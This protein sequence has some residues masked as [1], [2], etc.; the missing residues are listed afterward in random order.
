MAIGKRHER[1]V[2]DI[3]GQPFDPLRQLD[4]GGVE[5]M[6]WFEMEYCNSDAKTGLSRVEVEYRYRNRTRTKMVSLGY[7]PNVWAA[8]QCTTK[9]RA[10]EDRTSEAW[11]RA[12]DPRILA[13]DIMSIR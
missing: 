8:D 2:A 1:Y 5:G 9:V 11:R 3:T 10:E 4:V 13:T 12:V 7:T 6:L